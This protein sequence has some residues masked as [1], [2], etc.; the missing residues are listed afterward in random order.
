MALS[1]YAPGRTGPAI[2]EALINDLMVY[3]LAEGWL[4]PPPRVY[5]DTWGT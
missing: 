1:L 4:Q 2:L 3:A 5:P